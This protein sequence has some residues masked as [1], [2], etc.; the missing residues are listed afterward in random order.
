MNEI[1]V[2]LQS[3]SARHDDFPRSLR[4]LLAENLGNHDRIGI[5]PINNPPTEILVFDS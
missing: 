3:P 2:R 4:R 5:D 1:V